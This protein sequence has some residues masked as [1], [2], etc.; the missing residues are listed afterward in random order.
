MVSVLI[1]THEYVCG[2]L[3]KVLYES[4][5]NGIIGHVGVVYFVVPIIIA[6]GIITE[7]NGDKLS[8]DSV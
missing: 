3:I 5:M 7:Y 1:S 2:C 6:A 8:M 4:L